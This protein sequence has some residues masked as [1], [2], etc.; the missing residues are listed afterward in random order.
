MMWTLFMKFKGSLKSVTIWVNSLFLSILPFYD[1]MRDG[2]PQL[3]PYLPDNA[4]KWMALALVVLNISLRFKTKH[5][6][7]DKL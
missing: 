4:Y 2:L 3:Q 6:L 5:D 1:E 7:A